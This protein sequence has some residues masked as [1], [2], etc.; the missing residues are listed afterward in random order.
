[1]KKYE[2]MYSSMPVFLELSATAD[3]YMGGRGTHRLLSYHN[4]PLS[5]KTH[6]IAFFFLRTEQK[7]QLK[8]PLYLSTD[9]IFEKL[10]ITILV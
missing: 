3:Y 9:V 10:F 4:I 2:R 5:R 7:L 1:M 6:A 8:L